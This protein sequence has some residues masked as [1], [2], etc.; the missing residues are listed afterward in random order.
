MMQLFLNY[1][2]RRKFN[3]PEEPRTE[4]AD[5]KTILYDEKCLNPFCLRHR[6]SNEDVFCSKR[7]MDIH[8]ELFPL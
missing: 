2:A 5:K 7:C 6:F 1:E 3:T 4:D 8:E